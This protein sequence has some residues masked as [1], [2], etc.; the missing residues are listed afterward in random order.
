MEIK[1]IADLKERKYTPNESFFKDV[2]R[3]PFVH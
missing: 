2:Q 1:R 3:D